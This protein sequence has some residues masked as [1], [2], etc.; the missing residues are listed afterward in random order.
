[1]QIGPSDPFYKEYL[2]YREIGEEIKKIENANSA[3]MCKSVSPNRT[4]IGSSMI[5]SV[6]NG[7]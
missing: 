7:S 3:M 1:M 6:N 5:D 2:R 4:A